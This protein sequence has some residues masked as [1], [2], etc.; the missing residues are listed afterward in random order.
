MMN[1]KELLKSLTIFPLAAGFN[2]I[3]S[4]VEKVEVQGATLSTL[5]KHSDGGNIFRSIGVEP[6]IN[7]RGTFTILSG[8]SPWPEVEEATIEAG[9]YFVQFDELA[10]GVGRRL[11]ELTGAEWGMVSAGCAAAMKHCTAG[12]I[13]GGNPEKLI[14]ISDLKGF[15]KDEVIIPRRSRNAYDHAIRNIGVKI[16]TVDDMEELERAINPRTALI[17]IVNNPFHWTGETMSLENIAAVARPKNVPILYDAANEDLTVTDNWDYTREA[18]THNLRRYNSLI[19]HLERGANV[20]CYS[21]GKA[22][23]GPQ[24]AG[25]LLG[26]KDIVMSAWQASS[27]HH[28]PGRDNKVSRETMMGMV[29]AVEAWMSVDHRKIWQEWISYLDYIASHLRGIHSVQTRVHYP[30]GASGLSNRSP[31]LIV[32]WDPEALNLTGQ[33]MAEILARTKPR[34]AVNERAGR[35]QP[36]DINGIA[37]TAKCIKPGEERIVADRLREILQERR[38]P[39]TST[40][41]QPGGNLS[42]QWD[43][44]IQFFRDQSQHTFS[45]EQDGNW[46]R[47]FHHSD[48]ASREI[49]GT[50][51]GDQIRIRSSY[52]RPG[53]GIQYLFLGKLSDQGSIIYGNIY[54]G[55]YLNATFTAQRHEYRQQ[56]DPIF[57]PGGPPL[58]S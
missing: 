22:I 17:Y 36:A 55:E 53:N 37:I 6:I 35:G 33:E 38:S 47:G 16:V 1:R 41:Q 31:E 26:D 25:L 58:A 44:D 20:V 3:Q 21:G 14:Q 54:M 5:P 51:E 56:R 43:V 29:A 42:G 46:L 45:L 11:A 28:G 48:F 52:S 18:Y 34:I 8:S 32:T 23:R 27:P 9:R 24:N 57:V 19:I 4:M 10:E 30:H 13:A 50:I 12:V 39:K 2:S 7:C 15:E 40:M 49:H